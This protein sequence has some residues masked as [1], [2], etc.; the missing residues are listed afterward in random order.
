MTASRFVWHEL[1]TG[2]VPGA[3]AFYA[4]IVGWTA[5]D[6]G[7]PGVAYT[8]MTV[9]PAQVA[10]MME[11]PAALKAIG[12]P[13]TWSGYV[14]V[15][16]V[17]AA[18]ARVLQLGGKVLNPAQDI[19]GIGRFAVVAD[20]QGAAFMLFKPLRDDP[21]P[22]PPR[23]APGT[24]GWN[25]LRALDGATVFAFYA[26]LF[27][28]KKGEPLDMGEM[29]IYQIFEIDGVPSGAIMDKEPGA[30][31]PGWRYYFCVDSIGAAALRVETHGG[32]VTMGPHEVPGGTWVLHGRDPQG[33]LFALMSPSK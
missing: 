6:A 2:D 19:P 22:Q 14:S 11:T 9:G 20:P 5:Q 28:W 10:G 7:M 32:Q 25:E 24:I 3:A 16:D 15:G 4:G 23:D 27:G 8:L 21:P 26:K 12:A 17:D 18:E 13:S 30:S 29:G 33:V 31:L 1:M